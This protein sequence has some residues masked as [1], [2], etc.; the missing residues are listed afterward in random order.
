MR[1][2]YKCGIDYDLNGAKPKVVNKFITYIDKENEEVYF[3][4]F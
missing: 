3:D 2:E 1:G 4:E